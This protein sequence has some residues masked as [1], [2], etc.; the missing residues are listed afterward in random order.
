VGTHS[1]T[2]DSKPEDPIFQYSESSL[3]VLRL[4]VYCNRSCCR[5]RIY[6]VGWILSNSLRFPLSADLS[7]IRSCK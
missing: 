4:F 6:T 2:D 1:V 3:P 7:A 5:W